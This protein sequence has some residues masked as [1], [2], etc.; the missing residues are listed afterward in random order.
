[1]S[2][3]RGLAAD[4]AAARAARGP[5]DGAGGVSSSFFCFLVVF[6]AVSHVRTLGR[7]AKRASARE[8]KGADERD[9]K[10]TAAAAPGE[11]E[12]RR[13]GEILMGEII[14]VGS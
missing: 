11:K 14:V 3:L 6:Y 5:S 2:A 7:T 13:P 10:A 4:A 8:R 9:K 1:V 12:K